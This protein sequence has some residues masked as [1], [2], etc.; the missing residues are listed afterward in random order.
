MSEFN[1]E[2]LSALIDGEQDSDHTNTLDKLLD[3]QDMKDI[4]SRY[5]LIGDCLR[6]HLPEKISSHVSTQVSNAL[7]D[8][9][10]VLSPQT[11]KRFNMKPVAGF[12]IAASVAM[13]A[14][15]GLQRG[16]EINPFSNTPDIAA[17]EV[18]TIVSQPQSFSFPEPQ[19]LPAAIN[20]SD[21]PDSIAN[22]RL[23]N[24]LMNHNEYRSNSGM[25]AILPYVRIVT[26]ESQEQ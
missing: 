14:I 4:W 21:T 20:K 9:P 12:A 11:T 16:D 1:N 5:H 26:I 23:N 8:E 2:Q 10:T 13:V 7:R 15:L 24:Y 17:S 18:K 25:N 19:I 6:G 3:D 22:Q